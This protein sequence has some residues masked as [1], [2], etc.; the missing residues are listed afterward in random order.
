MKN[1]AQSAHSNFPLDLLCAN[2]MSV[3]NTLD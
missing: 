2:H 1:S 3:L